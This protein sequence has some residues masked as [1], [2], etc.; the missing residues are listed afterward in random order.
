MST[1]PQL[2]T[3]EEIGEI[4]QVTGKTVLGWF[5]D[6]L[7]PAEVAVGKIYRFDAED[8]AKALRDAA[9]EKRFLKSNSGLLVG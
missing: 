6:G 9:E 4:Y 3:P 1:V 8:L 5:H 2:K 7:I